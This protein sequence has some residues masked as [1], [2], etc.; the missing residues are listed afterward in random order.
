MAV[1]EI[2]ETPPGGD[3]TAE[4]GRYVA[5]PPR[6]VAHDLWPKPC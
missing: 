3:G 5:Y 1:V 2:A 6:P 4:K